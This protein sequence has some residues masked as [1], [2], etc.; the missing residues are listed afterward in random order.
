[1]PFQR[2]HWL[3]LYVHRLEKVVKD[4][5]EA[6]VRIAIVGGGCS[7]YSYDI[8]FIKK[9]SDEDQ[10]YEFDNIA[11]PSVRKGL[12]IAIDIVKTNLTNFIYHQNVIDL[13][14]GLGYR[15]N[16]MLGEIELM[17]NWDNTVPSIQTGSLKFSPV[18]QDYNFNTTIT[19]Q[20]APQYLLYL[21]HSNQDHL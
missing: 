16:T 20:R 2:K 14:F 12:F 11:D 8:D 5:E 10:I 19:F 9:K 7:G 1:M 15:I 13:Q 21:N 18:F 4:L 3:R 6:G 17:D